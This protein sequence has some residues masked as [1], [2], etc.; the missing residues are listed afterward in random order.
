MGVGDSYTIK[1]NSLTLGIDNMAEKIMK[2][3]EMET[4]GKSYKAH[5]YS[6]DNAEI[7]SIDYGEYNKV[8]EKYAETEPPKNYKSLKEKCEELKHYDIN[9]LTYFL[10]GSRRVYKVDDIAYNKGKNRSGIYPVIAGQIAVGCLKRIN[11]RM[12]KC[13][14]NCEWDLALPS[15]ADADGKPGF[16][17]ALNEKIKRNTN[18]TRLTNSDMQ[19]ANIFSYSTSYANK[20]KY[21]DK[22]IIKIQDR[23]IELE[24]Q[25]V[26]DLVKKK[27]LNQRNYLVKDGSLEYRKSKCSNKNEEL[28]FKNNYNWVIGVSKNFNPEICKDKKGKSNPG[29]IAELPLYSRTPVA[30]YSYDNT[31]FAVW[32]VRIRDKEKTLS[33]FDGILKVEKILVND[34]ELDKGIETEY[35]DSL[36]ASLINERTPTCYGSDPRWANHIYPVYLTEQYVKSKFIS[37]ESFLHLF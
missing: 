7:P 26:S 32:Y 21:E 24:K 36:S 19:L 22:G 6:L 31:K 29:F 9:L 33:P 16:F 1:V 8:W 3:L 30:E 11:K 5:K 28:I 20:E 2:Y 12:K 35:V 23:M 37:T 10:D 27:L 18:I 25:T 14:F 13:I 34:D 15:I 17:E 4:G